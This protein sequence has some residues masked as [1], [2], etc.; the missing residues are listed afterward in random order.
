MLGYQE[1]W[2]VFTTPIEETM[3]PLINVLRRL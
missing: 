2:T 3:D 1:H